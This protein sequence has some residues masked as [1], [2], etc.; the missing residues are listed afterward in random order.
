MSPADSNMRSNLVQTESA[1][2]INDFQHCESH[3][4]VL[5]EIYQSI[6]GGIRESHCERHVQTSVV[7]RIVSDVRCKE[8][9]KAQN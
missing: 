6:Q 4:G 2:Q 8:E 1:M 7:D 9:R 5:P 3:L